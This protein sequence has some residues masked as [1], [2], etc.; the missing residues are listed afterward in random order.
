MGDALLSASASAPK[1]EDELTLLLRD[2]I[3]VAMAG[4]LAR[5][6]QRQAEAEAE[7][8]ATADRVRNYGMAQA[9]GGYIGWFSFPIFA[10]PFGYAAPYPWGIPGSY[11]Q[12]NNGNCAR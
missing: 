7:A 8:A 3:K 6:K 1:F 2:R 10:F 5:Q 12:P 11:Y 9:H 4:A